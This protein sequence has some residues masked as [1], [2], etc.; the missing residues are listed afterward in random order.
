M[1]YLRGLFL[2]VF[3]FLTST[4]LFAAACIGTSFSGFY[5]DVSA[6]GMSASAACTALGAAYEAKHP[7]NNTFFTLGERTGDAYA[8]SHNDTPAGYPSA[9]MGLGFA[10]IGGDFSCTQPA[11]TGD[12]A[13]CKDAS[14]LNNSTLGIP[15][16][17]ATM[18]G[19]ISSGTSVCIA[20]SG[21]S[22][23]TVGCTANFNLD[24]GFESPTGQPLSRGTIDTQGGYQTLPCDLATAD[25]LKPP[26]ADVTTCP[27]GEQTG[28]INGVDTCKPYPPGTKATTVEKVDT[29]KVGT[30]AT[31]TDKTSTVCSGTSCTS[32]TVTTT[33]ANGT[34]TTSTSTVSK[35][36]FCS[37]KPASKQCE[38]GKASSSEGCTASSSTTGCSKFGDPGEMAETP[39]TNVALTF[40]REAGFGPSDSACPAPRVLNIPGGK[41]I[42]MSFDMYCDFARGMRPFIIGF[43]LLSAAGMVVFSAT[44]KG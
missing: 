37:S 12:A 40:T 41:T 29:K 11:P 28:Q 8:C 42:S 27:A 6:T 26:K 9:R 17:E 15:Y 34:S 2:F 18:P 21:M 4:T 32:T 20:T 3:S 39:N 38:S 16:E 44:R 31:V 24:I 14:D 7:G 10:S 13:R 23:S 1:F 19:R 35:D 36:D 22:N 30:G 33:T 5:Y 43:A 25:P